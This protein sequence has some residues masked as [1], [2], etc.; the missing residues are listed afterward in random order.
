VSALKKGRKLDTISSIIADAD[1]EKAWLIRAVAV[2]QVARAHEIVYRLILG[3][4]ISLLLQANTASPPNMDNARAMYDGAKTA[5]PN[6]YKGF[7]FEAWIRFAMNAGLLR[8]EAI[9]IG[10][11]VLRITPWGQD[12]LHYLVQNSLT[13]PKPG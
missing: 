12:F 7:S 9:G 5:Y 6:L 13:N 1:V 3:S 4:Q 8:E 11:S 2:W 10:P